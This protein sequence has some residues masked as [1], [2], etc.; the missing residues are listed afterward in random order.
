[1]HPLTHAH[2]PT[3]AHTNTQVPS[4][5][6]VCGVVCLVFVTCHLVEGKGILLMEA[7]FVEQHHHRRL[8]QANSCSSLTAELSVWGSLTIWH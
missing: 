3:H 4:G 1:M 2:A 7:L 6:S 5:I 8:L